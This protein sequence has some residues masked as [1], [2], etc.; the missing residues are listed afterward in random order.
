MRV[1][2]QLD[3]HVVKSR[4]LKQEP[5]KR[6]NDTGFQR[7]LQRP[8]PVSGVEAGR[9]EPIDQGIAGTEPKAGPL[10]PFPEGDFANLLTD[11]APANG[12]I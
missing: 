9:D 5:R 7:P 6:R 2:V 1:N 3:S 10:E 12:R 11:D 4:N 8:C